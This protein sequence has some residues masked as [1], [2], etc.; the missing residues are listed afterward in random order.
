[1]S[2]WKLPP[3]P[4]QDG[5]DF[6]P[7]V[8]AGTLVPFGYKETEDPDLLDPV[9]E[10]L[11][12]LERAKKLVKEYSLRVVADWLSKETGRY[13]SHTGLS[14][15]IKNESKTKNRASVARFYAKRYKEAQEKAEKLEAKIGGLKTYISR[16]G[17]TS[18]SD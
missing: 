5:K 8:R 6:L 7:I 18:G 2:K 15:R 3:I 16:G 12:A 17:D 1:M 9:P 13:I 11:I 14:K 4:K 10:E